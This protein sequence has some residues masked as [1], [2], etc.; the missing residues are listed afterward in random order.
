MSGVGNI[1]ANISS[2]I[3]SIVQTAEIDHEMGKTVSA[4]VSTV[5]EKSKRAVDE[6]VQNHIDGMRRM[7]GVKQ[8]ILQSIG[9]NIDVTA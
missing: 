8:Q 9:Q 1:I 4:H 2:T 6:V 5:E 3:Q 7:L